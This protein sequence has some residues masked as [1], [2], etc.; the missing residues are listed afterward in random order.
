[1]TPKMRDASTGASKLSPDPERVI[2]GYVTYRAHVCSGCKKTVY[3]EL[4]GVKQPPHY[5]SAEGSDGRVEQG[6]F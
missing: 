1:M 3:D 5:C 6:A 2:G 4:F